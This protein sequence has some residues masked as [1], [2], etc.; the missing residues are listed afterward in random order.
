ME[1]IPSRNESDWTE[2]S[3]VLFAV[4]EWLDSMKAR[5]WSQ[6]QVSAKSLRNTYELDQLFWLRHESQIV[7]LVF[8]MDSD[9]FF[10]PESNA[11]SSLY[12][13]KLAI[14]PDHSKK[15]YGKLALDEIR[16]YA[17][18][19]G[20]RWVRLDCD[21]RESLHR[22]YLSNGYQLVD[23]EPMQEYMVARYQLLTS[24]FNSQPSAAGTAQSAAPN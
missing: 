22:F 15:G 20:C 13:H 5:L 10:W 24:Q 1:L 19:K 4:A 11:E 21:D 3:E 6:D 23:V 12:F 7:G 18:S 8:L 16:K 17:I 9:P 14:H 2:A